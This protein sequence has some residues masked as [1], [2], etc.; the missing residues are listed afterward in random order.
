[1][2]VA[3]V[4][5]RAPVHRH[6]AGGWVRPAVVTVLLLLA[7]ALVAMAIDAAIENYR[8][9]IAL[10]GLDGKP[11]PIDLVVAGE[12]MT[13]PANMIRFRSERRGGGLDRVDLM[14][15]WP[16]LEGFSEARADAFKDNSPDAP[17]IFVSIAARDTSLDSTAR[18]TTVYS[19]FFDGAVV[20]GPAGLVGRRL[21]ADSGYGGEIVFFQPRGPAPFVARCLAE[22][23]S[24]IPATCIRDVNVGHG[25]SMLYRFD[26]TRLD[27]WSRL[28]NG[29]YALF[30]SFQERH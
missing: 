7:I 14:L 27:D 24:E 20:P 13:I 5:A 15:H 2:A 3:T 26:R 18:L 30:A 29:L 6:P 11:S 16:T 28:D 4:S 17:I 1:M 23:T 12:P 19:H 9:G 10:R 25:L 8:D 22:A 21:K